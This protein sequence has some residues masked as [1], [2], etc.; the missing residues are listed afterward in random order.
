M[1]VFSVDKDEL[2][3]ESKGIVRGNLIVRYFSPLIILFQIGGWVLK[4]H[5]E[6]P[7]HTLAT[8]VTEVD[9]KGSIPG[10]VIKQAH[11][12]QGYQVVK[13]RKAVAKFKMEH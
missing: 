3:P 7:N 6:N 9:L 4:P 12:D 11:K 5:P 8:Y 1:V 13:M 10:F 2:Y